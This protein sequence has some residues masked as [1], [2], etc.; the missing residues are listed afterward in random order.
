MEPRTYCSI[1]KGNSGEIRV[2]LAEYQGAQMVDVRLFAPRARSLGEPHPTKQGV[3][4]ARSRLRELI[5]GLQA[6][7]REGSGR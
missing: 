1:R 2:R 3:C 5:A 4:I 7:E 6:I